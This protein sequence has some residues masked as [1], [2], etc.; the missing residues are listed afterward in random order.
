MQNIQT[1]PANMSAAEIVVYLNSGKYISSFTRRQLLEKLEHEKNVNKF[2]VSNEFIMASTKNKSSYVMKQEE[3]PTLFG[4]KNSTQINNSDNKSNTN[5][6]LLTNSSDIKN[7]SGSSNSLQEKQKIIS[8]DDSN[9]NQEKKSIINYN[10][11]ILSKALPNNTSDGDKSIFVDDKIVIPFHDIQEIYNFFGIY[12]IR[13][14]YLILNRKMHLLETLNLLNPAKSLIFNRI[15]DYDDA[16]V[17]ELH[18][19]KCLTICMNLPFV[20]ECINMLVHLLN[21]CN[22]N[23]LSKNIINNLIDEVNCYYED[24]AH[25]K[26]LFVDDFSKYYSDIDAYM[27]FIGTVL[28]KISNATNDKILY[29]ISEASIINSRIDTLIDKIVFENDPH[30]DC[31]YYVSLRN[32]QGNLFQSYGLS[33]SIYLSCDDE[34]NLSTQNESMD[35]IVLSHISEEMFSRFFSKKHFNV[36]DCDQNDAYFMKI[37]L[38]GRKYQSISIN[39]FMEDILPKAQMTMKIINLPQDSSMYSSVLHNHDLD[40]K[41]EIVVPMKVHID[42]W[43]KRATHNNLYNMSET[44]YDLLDMSIKDNYEYEDTNTNI[45]MVDCLFDDLMENDELGTIIRP[46]MRDSFI[47]LSKMTS[48]KIEL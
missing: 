31:D 43:T 34:I 12:R 39:Y 5:Y 20:M 29:F 25:I 22:T 44:E 13:M 24:I 46:E 42:N 26:N 4:N 7:V 48:G 16:V 18:L 21:E 37:N 36:F 38:R 28:K 11:L 40:E 9:E 32:D 10:H 23:L 8:Q 15:F 14:R 2:D 3:F 35:D 17:E 1:N 27:Q 19:R 45:F 33:T 6:N 47:K 30:I 41:I